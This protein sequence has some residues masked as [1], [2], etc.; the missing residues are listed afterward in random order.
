MENNQQAIL[1]ALTAL[2][3][4]GNGNGG[5]DD[6]VAQATSPQ[7]EEARKER[8]TQ[9]EKHAATVLPQYIAAYEDEPVSVQI[10]VARDFLGKRWAMFYARRALEG[11]ERARDNHFERT[12][13]FAESVEQEIAPGRQLEERI[14]NARYEYERYELFN[15]VGYVWL[16][17]LYAQAKAEGD[18]PLMER[19][20]KTAESENADISE[21]AYATWS[22]KR[23]DENRQRRQS[24]RQQTTLAT[25]IDLTTATPSYVS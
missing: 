6:P 4:G 14:A 13:A 18:L 15:R 17:K 8:L 11:M 10:S 22:A 7:I 16:Q 19:I 20:V 25:G 5:N 2:L 24:E 3:T 1:S 21:K 12:G 23:D 9:V